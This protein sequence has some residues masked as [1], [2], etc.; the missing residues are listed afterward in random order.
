MVEDFPQKPDYLPITQEE[1]EQHTLEA[2]CGS[3]D[4]NLRISAVF[5]GGPQEW[6]MLCGDESFSVRGAVACHSSERHQLLLVDDPEPMVR[7]RLAIYGT[8]RVRNAL[9]EHGESA[10]E[11]LTEIAR[12]GSISTR[13]RLVDMAWDQP[14][15]LQQI[16]RY[17]PASD[18]EKLLSHPNMEVRIN[19]ASHGSRTQCQRVLEMPCPPHNVTAIFMRYLLIDRLKELDEVAMALGLATPKIRKM[20]MELST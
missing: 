1:F 6:D 4:Y 11:V 13:H 8:D 17:L 12:F 16:A 20:E 19:A 14:K 3:S 18:I 15:I 2:W 5:H 7:K 9:L 10:P